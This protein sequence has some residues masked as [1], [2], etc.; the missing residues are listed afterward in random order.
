MFLQRLPGSH[1]TGQA[2]LRVEKS[3]AKVVTWNVISF[4]ITP[5]SLWTLYLTSLVILSSAAKWQCRHKPTD[6]WPLH[7]VL[8]QLRWKWFSL[9]I[10]HHL[11][12]VNLT[13][14][15][16]SKLF[17]SLGEFS[18]I[19]RASLLFIFSIT[20]HGHSLLENRVEVEWGLPSHVPLVSLGTD[21]MT[22]TPILTIFNFK[23]LP[24]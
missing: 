23:N 11:S 17:H 4:S 24:R 19:L 15:R 21:Q 12:Q 14:H 18:Q 9:L 16:N 8:S 6:T 1:V 2:S 3:W 7:W 13:L 10:S 20:Q 5:I 22:P